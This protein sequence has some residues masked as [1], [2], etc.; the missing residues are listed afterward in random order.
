MVII[1]RHN[2]PSVWWQI[3]N[4][5]FFEKSRKVIHSET[6]TKWLFVYPLYFDLFRRRMGSKNDK[7]CIHNRLM[8]F[9]I[10]CMNSTVLGLGNSPFSWFINVFISFYAVGWGFFFVASNEL[11][12]SSRIFLKICSFRVPTCSSLPLYIPHINNKEE[13]E[14]WMSQ[15]L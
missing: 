1:S 4:S 5:R 12:D 13:N 10:F 15:I 3:N 8:N 7:Q 11:N 6:M 14:Q 9:I 2:N